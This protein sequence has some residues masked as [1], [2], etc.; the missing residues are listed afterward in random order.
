[1]R[2]LTTDLL[3]QACQIFLSLAY[4]GNNGTVPVKKRCFLNLPAGQCM[5]AHLA[6]DPAVNECCQAQ[7]MD[8][9]KQ[10]LLVRLGCAHYPYLKLKVQRISHKQGDVWVFSVDTHDSFSKTSFMP[11]PGHPEAPAWMALQMQNA[12]L[13]ERIEAAWE[14]AGLMTFNG[15]L[16]RDL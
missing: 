12:A 7:G 4:P 5:F 8:G 15:L 16:R 13:K 11:P 1:M 6:N 9:D 2:R 10:A 3:G 14:Q